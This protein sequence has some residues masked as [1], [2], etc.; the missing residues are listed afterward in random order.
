VIIIRD[1]LEKVVVWLEKFKAIGDIAVNFDP[2]HA[3]LPW[4]GVRFLLLVSA[5]TPV[6]TY[7]HSKLNFY[8]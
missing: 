2:I 8:R 1:Q 7:P 6:S 5:I 4:A 3:A